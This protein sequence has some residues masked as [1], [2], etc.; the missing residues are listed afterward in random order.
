MNPTN[1][2]A[3][4]G[5]NDDDKGKKGNSGKPPKGKNPAREA[6]NDPDS[7]PS[8]NEQP[9]AGNGNNGSGSDAAG[10]GSAP[11]GGANDDRAGEYRPANSAG[12]TDNPNGEETPEALSQRLAAEASADISRRADLNRL[13]KWMFTRDG[14]QNE[15]LTP[16]GTVLVAAETMRNDLLK[17]ILDVLN[18]MDVAYRLLEKDQQEKIIRKFGQSADNA[19]RAA[20]H[21]I[22]TQSRIALRGE[23]KAVKFGESIQC[24][25]DI[26]KSDVHRHQ[27]ADQTGK[28]VLI[29]I[30]DATPYIQGELPP[31]IDGRQKPLFK[32]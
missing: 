27:L 23:V 14:G 13:M 12:S 8:G 21:V 20:V 17:P 26:P 1:D 29:V 2:D 24:T 5:G 6:A 9:A 11:A 19:I 16:E 4:F 31:A 18:G 25:L 10:V 3:L 15:G 22:G 28:T 7:K 32:E 30:T